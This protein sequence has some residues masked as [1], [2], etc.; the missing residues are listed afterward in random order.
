MKRPQPE[1]LTSLGTPYVC[2]CS[3]KAADVR[4]PRDPLGTPWGP[5]RDP[6]RSAWGNSQTTR[7]QG[8]GT[9]PAAVVTATPSYFCN[10]LL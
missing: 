1:S 9:F 10:R 8:Q 7:P 2:L 5:P 4:P 3:G 6:S